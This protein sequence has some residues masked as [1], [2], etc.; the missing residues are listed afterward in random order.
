M[1]RF[2]DPALAR[3]R[4]SVRIELRGGSVYFRSDRPAMRAVGLASRAAVFFPDGASRGGVTFNTQYAC[5]GT[6]APVTSPCPT[7]ADTSNIRARSWWIAA[8][9]TAP[10]AF[11]VDL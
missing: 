1:H 10:V 8:W 2:E 9:H 3:A 4:D 11:G 5:R 7:G 6:L